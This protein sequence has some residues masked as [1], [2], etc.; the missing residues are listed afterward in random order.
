MEAVEQYIFAPE[1]LV[2]SLQYLQ[3]IL[4]QEELMKGSYWSK[5]KPLMLPTQK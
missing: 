1:R 2:V 5:S 4:P 3:Q